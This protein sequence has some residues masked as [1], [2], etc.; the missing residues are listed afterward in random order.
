MRNS[1]GNTKLVAYFSVSRDK[2]LIEQYFFFLQ[3]YK[4]FCFPV[5]STIKWQLL[6]EN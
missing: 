2:Y 4:Q 3:N 6:Q 5:W 1:V